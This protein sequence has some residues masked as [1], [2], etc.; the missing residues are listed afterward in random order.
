MDSQGHRGPG[1]DRWLISYADFITLLFAVFVV[2]F[3]S[4]QNDKHAAKRVSEAVVAAF[5]SGVIGMVWRAPPGSSGLTGKEGPARAM[6]AGLISSLNALSRNLRQEIA[7][8]K[9]EV[10]LEPRGLV[11]SLR[12]AVFYQSG[13]AA[14]SPDTFSIIDK[15]ADIILKLPNPVRLEGHTDAVPIHNSRFASNWELSAARS[16][17]ML[18]LLVSRNKIERS[19]LSV[20]GFADT[21]PV[22][23]N[24]DAQG[25]A[26]N[27]RVDVV[28]LNQL[29][30]PDGGEPSPPGR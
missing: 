25:R 16:I 27:R 6:D 22:S 10:R 7:A 15:L 17:A 23:S 8:G 19:R 4:A 24:D 14:I 18:E 26:H 5:K 20:A 9:I 21:M 2:L 11:V 29:V 28:I 13:E 30:A 1:H 3:A 12:Q